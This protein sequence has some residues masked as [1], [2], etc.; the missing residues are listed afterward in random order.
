[1][2]GEKRWGTVGA[3]SAF[4]LFCGL[5]LGRPVLGLGV[6]LALPVEE[7]TEWGERATV[8]GYGTVSI[9]ID[10]VSIII[11]STLLMLFFKPSDIRLLLTLLSLLLAMVAYQLVHC[12]YSHFR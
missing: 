12:C 8:C 6:R 11:L 4:G 10:T 2:G 3:P 7:E 1:M 9:V 5:H